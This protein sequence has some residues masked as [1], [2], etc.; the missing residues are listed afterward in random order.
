[1]EVM[2][3]EGG[4]TSPK[5]GKKKGQ[6]L[7]LEDL[8]LFPPSHLCLFICAH[9]NVGVT[10]LCRERGGLENCRSA[11]QLNCFKLITS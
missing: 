6:H 1:M 5:T 4:Q 9:S 2:R 11:R 8:P 3:I 7:P 10:V